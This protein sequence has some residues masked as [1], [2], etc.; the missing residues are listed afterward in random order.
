MPADLANLRHELLNE[1]LPLGVIVVDGAGIIH[2]AN[3]RASEMT[4]Y[5]PVDVVG[6][7]MLD[8]L[9]EDDVEFVVASLIHG[10]GYPGMVMGPARIRY[11]HSDGT[12]RWTEYWAH[13]CP[14]E[15]GIEGF[16]VTM[17][18]ESVTDNLAIAVNDIAGGQPLD[19]CLAS[20]NRAVAGYPLVALG[21]VLAVD[22]DEFRRVG[23][24]PF[25]DDRFVADREMPW[26]TARHSGLAVDVEVEALPG[27]ARSAAARLGFRSVWVRPVVSAAG[28]VPATFVA[29][30]H[31]PGFASPNQERH[32]ASAVDVTRLAFDHHEYLL[33]LQRVAVTDYLT[34][35]PNRAALT[36]HLIDLDGSRVAALFVDLDHFKEV[37]DSFGHQRG[38]EVLVYAAQRL[39]HTVDARGALFRLGGDEFVVLLQGASDDLAHRAAELAKDVVSALKGPVPGEGVEA[40]GA[41][42]GVAVQHEGETAEQVIRRADVAML[43]AKRAG[44]GRWHADGDD[45]AAAFR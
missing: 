35:V 26:W 32:L 31:E 30:R 28:E 5:L 13:E 36:R 33:R 9:H 7:S 1:F 10:T 16:I 8:L 20:V 6:T 22:G 2:Y 42:V 3:S 40:L 44:K 14:S 4:G 29:W 34:G 18:T 38:D 23:V 11:R 17:A 45:D 15:F 24:W 12:T 37:N 27:D 41:S 25:A 19:D 39:A 43:H 21:T